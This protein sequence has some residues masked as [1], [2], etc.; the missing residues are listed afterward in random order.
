MPRLSFD[1]LYFG[2]MSLFLILLPFY[3]GTNLL[4]FKYEFFKGTGN[5]LRELDSNQ[6]PQGY[7]PCKLPL[8]YPAICEPPENS[9]ISTRGLQNRCST[10]ELRWLIFVPR[11]G[12]EPARALGPNDFKSFSYTIPTPWLLIPYYIYIIIKNFLKS[13]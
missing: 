11:A 9:E 8:L 2:L 1:P 13:N 3:F 5:L 10:A 6:R 4:I 12:L 7:E